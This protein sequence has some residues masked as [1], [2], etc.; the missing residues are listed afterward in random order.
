[1]HPG[2]VRRGAGAAVA[3]GDAGHV[4]R[5]RARP[6]D[7]DLGH[8]RDAGADPGADPWAA[9]L[10]DAYSW[11]WVFYINVP[12]GI[13]ACRRAGDFLQGHS[14]RRQPEVRLVRLRRAVVGAGALQLML[15]RGTT[16][17]WFSSTEDRDR[18]RW[19][20]RSRS[21]CSSVI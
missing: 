16:K 9:C 1:M 6:G 19:S 17:D 15:D 7:G 20:R 11:R 14:A 13:A 5:R 12:F 3:S 18:R 21:I 10:T 4:S 2:R 8:G